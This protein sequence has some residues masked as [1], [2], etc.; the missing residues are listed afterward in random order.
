[1]PEDVEVVGLIVNNGNDILTATENGYGKRTTID[2]YPK[3][4]RGIQGVIDIKTSERNG[5]VVGAVQVGDDDQ[6]ML[7]SNGGTLVRTSVNE[8]SQLGRNTQG[9]R[10]IRLVEGEQLVEVERVEALNGDDGADDAT[11]EVPES[12]A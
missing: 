5:A 8:V 4:G 9:V 12:G 1:M 11:G 2:E 3:K 10:L 7:I 6:I